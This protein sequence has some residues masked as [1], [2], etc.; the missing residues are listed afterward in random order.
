VGS[1]EHCVVG[2]KLMSGSGWV[3]GCGD[4]KAVAKR[5]GVRG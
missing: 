2:G 5:E 4:V 3:N 1:F